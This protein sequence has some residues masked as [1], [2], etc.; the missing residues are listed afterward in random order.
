MMQSLV[1]H[2]IFVKLIS[3]LYGK[4]GLRG[5]GGGG[6]QGGKFV[7]IITSLGFVCFMVIQFFNFGFRI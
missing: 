7:I 4:M 6:G 1:P 3:L 2:Q 5:G